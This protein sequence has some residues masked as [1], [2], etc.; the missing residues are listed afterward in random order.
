MKKNIFRIVM[1]LG[2][3]LLLVYLPTSCNNTTS[4]VQTAETG[5]TVAEPTSSQ[6]DNLSSA[7]IV[8]NEAQQTDTP[9]NDT[10]QNSVSDNDTQQS[11]FADVAAQQSSTLVNGLHP[12]PSPTNS[13]TDSMAADEKDTIAASETNSIIANEKDSVVPNRPDKFKVGISLPTQSL[14]RWKNDGESLVQQLNIYGIET[15]LQ[16]AGDNDI[17]TQIAQVEKMIDSDC[18]L[19]I[20]AAVDGFSF[21]PVLAVAKEKGIPVISFERLLMKTDA[22]SYYITFDA[23]QYG[24]SQGKFIEE[25]LGLKDNAGPFY[26]E[27]FTGDVADGNINFFFNE[28]MSIL[29]SYIDSGKLIVRSGQIGLHQCATPGWST[30]EAQKRMKALITDIGYGPNRKRLDAVLATNDSV[31]I[32]V[33][34][35]LEEA[36]YTKDNFPVLTGMDCDITSVRK[37]LEGKQTMSLFWDTRILVKNMVTMVIA[38]ANGTEVPINDTVNYNNNT[39]IIPSLLCSPNIITKDNAVHELIDSGYYTWADLQP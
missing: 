3:I 24:I 15:D 38:I 36:G 27:I 39:G 5:Q 23:W 16:F 30:E 19:L 26:I 33:G 25:S 14:S 2:F 35:A 7:S 1:I 9:G 17:P 28:A 32:G 4:S 37:I 34:N 29:Q 20:I 6:M 11:S 18:D 31:A 12:I 13:E 8:N 21:G 22:V 10:Q